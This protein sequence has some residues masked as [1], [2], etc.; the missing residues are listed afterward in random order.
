M[1]KNINSNF[2]NQIKN[3]KG[4]LIFLLLLI[5]GIIIMSLFFYSRSDSYKIAKKISKYINVTSIVD[6]GKDKK[7]KYSYID[8][9]MIYTDE[10][11]K[12]EEEKYAIAIAEYSSQIEAEIKAKFIEDTYKLSH[13]KI[14]GKFLEQIEE[15]K[16]CFIGEE[17][18]IFTYGGYLIRINSY[19]KKEYKKL[20][21][22]II[23]VLKT[24]SKDEGQ[25]ID[26]D[27]IKKYWDDEL[28]SFEKS[29]EEAKIAA[30][31]KFKETADEQ[32][33]KIDSCKGDECE[34]YLEEVL[35][36]KQYSEVEDIINLVQN[37]YDEVINK[38]KEIID[39]IN[40]LISA[41]ERSLNQN[42]Y[43]NIKSKIEELDDSYYEKNKVE[44]NKRLTKIEEKMYIKTC[45]SY[46]Y[47]ETLRFPDNYKGK[48]AY[49]FG[50]IYQKISSTQYRVGV[51]CTKYNYIEGYSCK[52]TIYVFYYGDT[53]LIEDDVIKMWGSMNGTVTYETVLGN[54]LTIP[55][56]NAKYISVQ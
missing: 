14:D 44:W 19:Y 3:Y 18:L 38:K 54:S 46:S 25:K 53:N 1:K 11:G 15:S 22:Q 26:Y 55:A 56:L 29:L 51:D 6:K 30:I 8:S 17:D 28:I 24:Y 12:V 27:T 36:Y 33:S 9:I 41:V 40:Q 50:V 31:D 43:D 5:L 4:M 21:K 47:K 45:S 42:D 37:K 48:N 20:K 23:N 35:Y 16:K 39:S 34:R 52:N 32:I 10:V 49:W 13:E 2:K 7:N